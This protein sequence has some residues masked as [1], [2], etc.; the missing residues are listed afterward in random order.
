MLAGKRR[1]LQVMDN[2][3]RTEVFPAISEALGAMAALG[4]FYDRMAVGNARSLTSTVAGDP[5]PS[6]AVRRESAVPKPPPKRPGEVRLSANDRAILTMLADG[7]PH[8]REEIIERTGSTVTN[9]T[10]INA[11]VSVLRKKVEGAGILI[12]GISGG[13]YWMPKPSCVLALALMEGTNS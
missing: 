10:S 5:E 3:H 8:A 6:L 2:F 1:M 4:E 7:E 9:L 11:K 12:E 13:R